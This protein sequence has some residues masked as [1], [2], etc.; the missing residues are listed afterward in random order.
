MAKGNMPIH[1]TKRLDDESRMRAVLLRIAAVILAIAVGGLFFAAL[2]FNPFE[3]Y[4]ELIKGA[5][6]TTMA[7]RMTVRLCV[8]LLITS[9]AVGLAFKMR[10]WNIG[11]EGQIGIGAIAASYIALF[12]SEGMPK[13]VVLILM[14]VAAF[15]AGGLYGVI[16]AYFKSKF[17]T[18]ET[19]FTLM[20][21][22]V[23]FYT[24]Q[25]L[26]Q[27]AWK[28]PTAWGFPKIARFSSNAQLPMVLGVHVGWIV[29]LAL[30]LLVYLY[31]NKTKQG[32]ELSVVGENENTARYAGMN[33]RKI[34][35]RTMFISAGLAGLAG[36]L[37]ASGADKT[38]TESIA[39]N[40]GFTAI[41]VAWLANLNPGAMVIVTALF[42]I[43]TKGS[44][45]IQSVYN[46]SPAAAE[47]FQGII[48]FFVLGSEFFIRYKVHF[49]GFISKKE[50]GKVK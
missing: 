36:M 33:V 18:N 49:A 14:A 27:G 13:V 3:V 48:L 6:G 47:V 17:G 34:V 26:A 35:I 31:M 32:Y 12:H 39:N 24:I 23:A 1:V 11:A 4:G 28:D 29:A 5:V 7:R 9:L 40:V 10:F 43:L 41:T 2:G 42:C 19:L 45:T 20:L 50:G 46:I 16:P 25:A 44:D 21:N 38:L 22:Y 15:V 30:V 37:Q 8:P